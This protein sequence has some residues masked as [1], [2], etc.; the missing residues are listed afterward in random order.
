[1]IHPDNRPEIYLWY[2]SSNDRALD[3]IKYFAEDMSKFKPEEVY[4]EPKIVTYSCV[5]CDKELK[6]KEC[7]SNGRYC[8]MNHQGPYIRGQDILMED[9]R[10]HCLYTLLDKKNEQMKWWNYMKKVHSI[11]YDSIN[12]ECSRL[13]HKDIGENYDDTMNCVKETFG[14]SDNINE[15]DNKLLAK[16]EREWKMYGTAYWP[17]IVVNNKTYRGD[18]TPDNVFGALCAGFRNLPDACGGNGKKQTIVISSNN[19]GIS[20]NALIIVVILLV[21]VNLL[22]IVLYRRCTNKEF[23]DDMQL[24][25]NSAVSQYFALSTKNNTSGP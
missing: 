1:M 19:E 5:F 11:C 25:V 14:G 2:T 8:A 12:E 16:M 4:F 21:I 9:L 18:I 13:G 17:S 3:F 23:N 24:Q 10:E 6:E 7:V 22:L 20:G 15:A